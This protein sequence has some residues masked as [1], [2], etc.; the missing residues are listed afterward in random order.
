MKSTLLEHNPNSTLVVN[1]QRLSIRNGKEEDLYITRKL[2]S[3]KAITS[4][5]GM[6]S[7]V[8]QKLTSFNEMN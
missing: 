8:N 5:L 6:Q 3:R 2:K 4:Q 1:L 7:R